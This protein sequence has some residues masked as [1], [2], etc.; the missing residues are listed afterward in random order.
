M[1]M[2]LVV[3]KADF[4][5]YSERSTGCIWHRDIQFGSELRIRLPICI[6]SASQPLSVFADTEY[7]YTGPKPRA[8]VRSRGL[9]QGISQRGTCTISR[10]S[11]AGR[12][13]GHL[14]N[15][16]HDPHHDVPHSVRH[17]WR[18]LY[19]HHLARESSSDDEG[20]EDH[21]HYVCFLG[22]LYPGRGD[23]LSG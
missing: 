20:G 6:A 18:G 14:R 8:V 23:V 5:M 4:R 15:S 2:S 11:S 22:G 3:W 13:N 17:A 1:P 12:P 16:S 7:G 19:T 21:S 9:A 10:K